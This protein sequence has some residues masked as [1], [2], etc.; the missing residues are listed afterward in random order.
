M[1]QSLKIP[2]MLAQ[3]ICRVLKN[4]TDI[5]S[6]GENSLEKHT[7]MPSDLTWKQMVEHYKR[8]MFFQTPHIPQKVLTFF[9]EKKNIVGHIANKVSRFHVIYKKMSRSNYISQIWVSKF[10][11]GIN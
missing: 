7:L 1:V 11:F 4:N 9:F 6:E 2:H 3:D 5:Q 8:N 10:P